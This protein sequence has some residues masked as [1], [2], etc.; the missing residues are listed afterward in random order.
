VK[1]TLF[2]AVCFS[3]LLWPGARSWAAASPAVAN[4]LGKLNGY[5]YCL[6]QQGLR[7]YHGELACSLSPDSEKSLQA[8]G[9]YDAKLWGAVKNFRFSVDDQAGGSISVQGVASA[10]TGNSKL[11]AKVG[12]LNDDLLE[13]LKAFFQFWKASTVEPLNAPSDMAQNDFKF[14]KDAKGFYVLETVPGGVTVNASFDPKGKMNGFSMDDNGGK[15]SYNPDFLY[16]K[17][18][19]LLMGFSLD[20]AGSMGDYRLKYGV[21]DRFWMPAAMTL[22]TK[23]PGTTHSVSVLFN[24][25]NFKVNQ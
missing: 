14:T 12:K 8:K 3:I 6:S 22:K 10:P 9:A 11:D 17:K 25:S 7:N 16:T 21:V 23:L 1:K 19:Y 24:F 15:T 13:D 18:G 2:R 4:F 20:S 5:Y